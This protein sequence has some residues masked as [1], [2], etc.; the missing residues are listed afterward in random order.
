V[1]DPR[2][3]VA[4]AAI[5]FGGSLLAT[6]GT[7]NAV[8]LWDAKTGASL[9][10][11]KDPGGAAVTSLAFNTMGTRLAVAGQNGATYVWPLAD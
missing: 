1:R 6:A 9:G 5:S 2:G 8:Y 11:I 3:A 10:T 7:G 4:T